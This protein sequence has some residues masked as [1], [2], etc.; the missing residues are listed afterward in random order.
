MCNWTVGTTDRTERAFETSRQVAG[1]QHDRVLFEQDRPG[2]SPAAKIRQEVDGLAGQSL[3]SPLRPLHD[4]ANRLSR[5]FALMKDG[6]HL[7]GNG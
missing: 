3:F 7:F 6:I 2:K 1:N 5:G 4:R